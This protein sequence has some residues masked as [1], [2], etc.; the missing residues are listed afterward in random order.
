MH[1]RMLMNKLPL[2][3]SGE[4]DRGDSMGERSGSFVPLPNPIRTPRSIGEQER[5]RDAA[6]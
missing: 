1:G 5:E 2:Q 3:L 6:R 4:I